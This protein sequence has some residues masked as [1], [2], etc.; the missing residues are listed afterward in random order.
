MTIHQKKPRKISLK[1]TNWEVIFVILIIHKGTVSNLHKQ[2]LQIS[3]EKPPK[4]KWAE[5]STGIS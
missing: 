1:N 4:D 3:K 5:D 2:L